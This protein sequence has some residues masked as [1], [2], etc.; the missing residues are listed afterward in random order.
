LAVSAPIDDLYR[1]QRLPAN[2][3]AVIEAETADRLLLAALRVAPV[4][5]MVAGFIE[6]DRWGDHGGRWLAMKEMRNE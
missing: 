2:H 6:P 5:L 3:A 4:R 1:V